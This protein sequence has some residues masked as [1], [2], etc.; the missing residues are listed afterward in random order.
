MKDRLKPLDTSLSGPDGAGKDTAVA[1]A[2]DILFHTFNSDLRVVR[3]DRPPM[4]VWQDDKENVRT[5]KLFVPL[6]R[7]INHAHE[8]GDR[9]G[10]IRLV[11]ASNA[12]NVIIQGWVIRRIA[13]SNFNPNLYLSGRNYF[14]D[15]AAYAQFYSPALTHLSIEQRL[16]FM[17]HVSNLP[18]YDQIYFM[19][20]D[21]ETALKRIEG[22][23]ASERIKPTG[24]V[25][26]RHRHETIEGLTQLSNT[27]EEIPSATNTVFPETQVF[28]VDASAPKQEV[29]ACIAG[30]I[31][32]TLSERLH[33]RK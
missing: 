12:A 18:D 28:I 33:S 19:Q 20:I 31:A 15:S 22:R 9:E 11:Q 26:W 23:V 10:N 3:L 4:C 29:A 25:L 30:N 17:K 16:K 27:F 14:T 6:F 21:P 2:L 7:L 13:S 5:Q 1:G 8:V 24:H 32:D